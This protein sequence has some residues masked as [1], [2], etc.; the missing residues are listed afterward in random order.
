MAASPLYCS[1]HARQYGQN[2]ATSPSRACNQCD[3]AAAQTSAASEMFRLGNSP[4]SAKE[5]EKSDREEGR[6]GEQYDHQQKG[7]SH[8]VTT[9]DLA[10]L[11]IVPE[12]LSAQDQCK[13]PE[14]FMLWHHEPRPIPPGSSSIVAG[15]TCAFDLSSALICKVEIITMEA[16][17]KNGASGTWI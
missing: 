6:Q 7:H 13:R 14:V 2:L 15:I 4:P 11:P 8:Y 3:L 17:G 9:F 10:L 1:R 12:S 16:G 5:K